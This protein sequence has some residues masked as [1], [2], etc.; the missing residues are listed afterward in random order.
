MLPSSGDIFFI[1]PGAFILVYIIYSGVYIYANTMLLGKSKKGRVKNEKGE[2]EK[3]KIGPKTGFLYG[4]RI[5]NAQ[6]IPLLLYLSLKY[7]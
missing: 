1:A 6:Y 7:I 3:E 2:G 4:L 5:Q